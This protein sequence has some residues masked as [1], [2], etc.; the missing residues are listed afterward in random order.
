MSF[1]QSACSQRANKGRQ[2]SQQASPAAFLV[3]TSLYTRFQFAQSIKVVEKLIH[4][5]MTTQ[6][7]AHS[8]RGVQF[9]V[10]QMSYRLLDL[11][12]YEEYSLLPLPHRI[13]YITLL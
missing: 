9:S 13:R 12:C 4:K 6:M 2:G 1:S 8:S 7:A 3:V 10:M 11:V 5:I